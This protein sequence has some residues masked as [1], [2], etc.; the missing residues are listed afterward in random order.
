[1]DSIDDDFLQIHQL[2]KEI[3]Q[4]YIVFDSTQSLILQLDHQLQLAMDHFQN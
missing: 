4:L 1:M 3:E 2:K